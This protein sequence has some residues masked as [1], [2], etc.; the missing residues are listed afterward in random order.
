MV[1][2]LTFFC[3]PV[4]AVVCLVPQ[5]IQDCYNGY[6]SNVH[7]GVHA[8]S[9]KATHEFEVARAKVA[10]FINA[11]SDRELVYT[12]NASEAIN[13]VANS[14]GGANLKA[15]DEVRRHGSEMN[16]LRSS[17]SLFT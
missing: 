14:W 9:A 4:P 13:L 11:K 16:G 2:L 1:T 8:L 3:N 7:R 15:G 12:R 10:R 6:N 17:C 5:A